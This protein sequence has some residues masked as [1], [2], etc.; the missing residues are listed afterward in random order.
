MIVR[1]ARMLLKH[2]N[3]LLD[4]SKLEAGKLKIELRDDRRCGAGAFHGFAFR[5]P[6]RRA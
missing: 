2:V 4:I 5:H 6:R 3:D 1:N